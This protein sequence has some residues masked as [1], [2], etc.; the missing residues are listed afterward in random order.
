MLV[1]I[2]RSRQPVPVTPRY[3]RLIRGVLIGKVLG[4]RTPEA[5]ERANAL[6]DEWLAVF[7]DAV[8]MA[9]YGG[10]V[11]R[12]ASALRWEAGESTQTREE[13]RGQP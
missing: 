13:P 12:M 3:L 2:G 9:S 4:A 6:L 8:E 5:C 7:P 11:A 10:F 1:P